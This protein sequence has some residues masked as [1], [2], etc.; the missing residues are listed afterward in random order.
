METILAALPTALALL[1]ALIVALGVVA[2]LTKTKRDDGALE[3]LQ[4][5]QNTLGRLLGANVVAKK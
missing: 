2:P 1:G 3:F 4:K 5:L